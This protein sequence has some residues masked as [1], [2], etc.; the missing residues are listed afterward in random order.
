MVFG[1]IDSEGVLSLLQHRE[2]PEPPVRPVV[3]RAAPPPPVEIE[4]EEEEEER[5]PTR[6]RHV[7]TAPEKRS[8]ASQASTVEPAAARTYIDTIGTLSTSWSSTCT[9]CACLHQK[10]PI[11]A[12]FRRRH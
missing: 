6:A 11:V 8:T 12:Y 1:L 2:P 3:R 4:E 5:V 10:L 9:R 7:Q